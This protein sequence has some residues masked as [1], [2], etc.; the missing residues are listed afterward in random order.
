MYF[1]YPLFVALSDTTIMRQEAM[2]TKK[3]QGYGS[4]VSATADH[5]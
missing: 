2:E 5:S 4:V 1:E 3:R